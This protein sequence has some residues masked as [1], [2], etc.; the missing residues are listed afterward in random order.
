MA[1]HFLRKMLI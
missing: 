1:A